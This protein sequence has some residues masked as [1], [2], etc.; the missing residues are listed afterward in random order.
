MN[1]VLSGPFVT[2]MLSLAYFPPIW[3][4]LV[5]S[6]LVWYLIVLL[7]LQGLADPFESPLVGQL[8]PLSPQSLLQLFLTHLKHTDRLVRVQWSCWFSSVHK[9]KPG[10]VKQET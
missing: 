4:S 8:G 1:L 7:E 5:Q 6:S 10:E 3:F 2:S 9:K